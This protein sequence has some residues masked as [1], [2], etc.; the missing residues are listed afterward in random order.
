MTFKVSDTELLKD[1]N[2]CN[3]ILSS[4]S[5]RVTPFDSKLIDLM[6]YAVF[7]L[8]SMNVISRDCNFPSILNKNGIENWYIEALESFI[9]SVE[10]YK[11]FNIELWNLFAECKD[12]YDVK[13]TAH[14][15]YKN[16]MQIKDDSIFVEDFA[17]HI[18]SKWYFLEKNGYISFSK[19]TELVSAFHIIFEFVER[20]SFK[21]ESIAKDTTNYFQLD[22]FISFPKHNSTLPTDEKKKETKELT[23]PL[24]LDTERA[25]KYFTKAIEAG[26][27][28]ITENG[29]QWVF[30]VG[31]GNKVSLGY[32]IQKV[33][34]P[35]NTESISE[36]DVNKLFGVDRIGSAITQMNNAKKPQKWKTAI[37]KLFE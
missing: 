24:K 34:C 23:L 18:I 2:N 31:S 13:Y 9:R 10:K 11:H 7:L 32:F 25:R 35:N 16:Y 26:Y 37:D 8:K 1:L 5:I 27:I 29:L 21:I 20:W 6:Q 14:K 22:R 3:L 28:K 33:F 4:M 30:M 12:V 15:L 17:N 19:Y 36:K